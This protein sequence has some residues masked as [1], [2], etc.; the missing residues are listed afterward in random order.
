VGTFH[1]ARR[2]LVSTL[3]ALTLARPLAAPGGHLADA[4]WR[5]SAGN[6]NLVADLFGYFAS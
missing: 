6:V 1:P 2:V 4:G 3:T 5:H